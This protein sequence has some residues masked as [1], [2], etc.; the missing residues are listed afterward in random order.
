[1]QTNVID[2]F[3]SKILFYL[4]NSATKTKIILKLFVVGALV[5]KASID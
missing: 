3:K 2:H 4:L 5:L 1:M